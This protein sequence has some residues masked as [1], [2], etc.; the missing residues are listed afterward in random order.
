M[1]RE[2]S[3]GRGTDIHS[4]RTLATRESSTTFTH[5]LL[6]SSLFVSS[7]ATSSWLGPTGGAISVF[8]EISRP[9]A[10][11]TLNDLNSRVRDPRFAATAKSL[12]RSGGF[13]TNQP[14]PTQP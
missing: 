14:V 11:F 12:R 1:P 8:L 10:S 4:W 7:R 2:I 3:P 6:Q 13:L 9:H 5:R